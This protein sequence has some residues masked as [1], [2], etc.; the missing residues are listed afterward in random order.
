MRRKKIFRFFDRYLGIPIVLFLALFTRRKRRLPIENIQNILFIKLAAIGDAILLIP[1][2]RK[3]KSSFPNAKI[4][5]MCSDINVSVIE[6]IPYIDKIINCRV[7]D[8]LKNPMN[9]YRFVK[10]LRKTKY[11][12]VIDAGQWERI[13]S[14]ITIF[15]KRD[16]SIGFRTEWQW[17]HVVNDAVTAHS[18]TKHEVENFMDLLIPLG[19][20]PIS[21]EYDY[22][23]LQLEFFL[24]KEHRLFS[25]DFWMKNN[26]ENKTVI[27]FHPGCGEN[28]K[29]REWALENY[30][31]VGKRLHDSDKNIVILITGTNYERY[32]CDPLYETL[33][34]YSINTAGKFTLEQSAALVENAELMLCSNTG[35]LH[36]STCV[37]TRTIGLHGPTNPV[38]WGAYNKNAI[39]IQSSKFC[40]PCL[41]LGHDYGCN[42]PTCMMEITPD[43]V[44]LRIR[45]VL[46]PELF[47]NVVELNN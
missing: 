7:Y 41:Y 44:Y 14:L 28:G 27:C 29:P 9:F 13:N 35:I 36:V 17:K 24:T 12:V 15:T 8:F 16:Y 18:R 47:L 3:L 11:E 6:K 21:G 33:K 31:S 20:V 37:G 45:E 2:L 23:D 30:I 22:D 10:E 26:L 32:L 46:H 19:I 34:D 38:K 4:T 25:K 43:E 1:T 39:T 5:F 42:K 40:S